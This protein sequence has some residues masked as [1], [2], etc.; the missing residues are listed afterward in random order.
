MPSELRMIPLFP[1]LGAAYL[2]L[3]GRHHS[4]AAVHRIACLA[5]GAAF[6]VSADVFFFWF[7]ILYQ[8]NGLTDLVGT[9]LASGDLQVDLALRMDALSG[10]LCLMVTFVGTLIHIYS[11]GYLAHEQDYA[12]FFAYLNLFCGAMLLL[13]LGDSL[14]VMFI[15]WEG[16]GLCSYL[17]IGFWY[18]EAANASAGKK[19]FITNRVGDLGFLIGMFL[20]FRA[21]GTLDIPVLVDTA[22]AGSPSL[23][24][25]LWWGQP[26][27]FWAALF[28]FMG[29][30]GKSAQIPLYVWLPDAMAGPT[31]VSALIHAATMVTAGVYMVARLGALYLAGPGGAGHRG[32]GRRADCSFRSGNRARAK[33]LQ[34][35]AGLLHHQ[36]AWFHVRGRGHRQ[37]RGRHLPPLHP[38]LLQGRPLPLCRLGH[39]R[40]GRLRRHHPHGRPGAEVALHDLGVPGL[41]AGHLR[42]ASFLGFLFQ[43]RDRRRRLRHRGIRSAPALGRPHAG[44]GLAGRCLGHGVLHVTALLSGLHWRMPGRPR[45][46]RAPARI[47]FRNGGTAAGAG[48]G[49]SSGRGGGPAVRGEQIARR[50]HRPLAGDCAGPATGS[51]TRASNGG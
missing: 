39:A 50:S 14:P 1:L 51:F 9:W 42:G 4:R 3:F 20:L 48:S 36:S 6:L 31:P 21:T 17:L 41:L 40:H 49:R 28:L 24:A 10:L 38:R 26:V 8:S 16:V 46:A 5:V 12:R 44:R 19:A 15:G 23:T 35:G 29:A 27:A 32:G 25:A 13:V 43:R 7:P 2:I 33:R 45:H 30:V 18:G 11:T 37:L 47:A 34:E 22:R